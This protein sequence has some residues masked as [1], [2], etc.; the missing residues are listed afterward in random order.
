[1]KMTD[2][3]D[4]ISTP[5]K[6]Q[7]NTKGYMVYFEEIMPTTYFRPDHFPEKNEG[8]ELIPTPEAA[9]A[10]ARR[11]VERGQNSNIVNVYVMDDDFKPVS[12][13]EAKIINPQ[14]HRP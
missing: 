6:K 3:M 9:W 4:V 13:Y 2:A 11:F 14:A 12:D 7:Y 1:M 10:L 8:E 5:E